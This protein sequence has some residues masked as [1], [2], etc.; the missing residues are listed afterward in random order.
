[1][2]IRTFAVFLLVFV[3]AFVSAGHA[4]MVEDVQK[5][6]TLRVGFFTFVP[7]AMQSKTGEFIGGLYGK[8]GEVLLGEAYHEDSNAP[9]NNWKGVIGATEKKPVQ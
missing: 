8:R 6:G 1:M 5:R 3:G 7:W 4:S 9:Q 2:R